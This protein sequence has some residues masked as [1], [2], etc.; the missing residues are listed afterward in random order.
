MKSYKSMR[1]A[2][3]DIGKLMSK[4]ERNISVGNTKSNAR[5]DQL[6]RA[7][8]VVKSADEIAR[9]HYNRNN[10]NAVAKA[11][12]KIDEGPAAKKAVV[13]DDWVEPAY[14]ETKQEETSKEDDK[15][16]KANAKSMVVK[17]EEKSTEVET[18]NNKEII[19]EQ[20]VEEDEWVEDAE[21][22]FVRKSELNESVSKS[23]KSRSK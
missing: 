18:E 14:E 6:G 2:N 15:T 1:G 8:R 11:S 23:K 20:S 17:E 21:G 16:P 7:G 3:V 10:P 5:G 22:N 12:I 4:Q 13:E 19:E 9:D